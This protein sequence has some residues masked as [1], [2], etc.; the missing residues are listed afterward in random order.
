MGDEHRDCYV[1][2]PRSIRV[3]LVTQSASRSNWRNGHR[4]DETNEWRPYDATSVHKEPELKSKGTVWQRKLI[5]LNRT[6]PNAKYLK[7]GNA[8]R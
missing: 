2:A 8:R 3:S 7:R 4:A 6:H 5:S 1:S